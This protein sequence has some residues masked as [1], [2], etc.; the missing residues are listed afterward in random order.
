M[1]DR[2]KI[3]KNKRILIVEDNQDN[4]FCYGVLLKKFGVIITNTEDG[5]NAIKLLGSDSFDIV[6][7]DIRLPGI[8]GYETIT[9]IRKS[10][11]YGNIPIIAVTAQAMEGD[12]KKAL[13]AGADEYIPKPITKDDL[14][15]K[16]LKLL[17]I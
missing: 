3:L 14:F 12:R 11:I 4:A 8:D 2:M 5:T 6:L 1:N 16:I 15:I 10:K 9:R 17:D 7:M 13:K